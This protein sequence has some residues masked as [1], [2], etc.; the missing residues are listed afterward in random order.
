MVL[1]DAFGGD[2]LKTRLPDGRWH[3]YNAV[4]GTR[5]DAT[6]TQFAAPP[7]YDDLPATRA[8]ALADTSHVQYRHLSNAW[9]KAWKRNQ[10]LG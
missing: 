4:D 8:E 10:K 5:F 2:I 9:A 7:A 3:F 1:Q 6:D